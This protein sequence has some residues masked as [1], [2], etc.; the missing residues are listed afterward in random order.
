MDEEEYD[1]DLIEDAADID[2]SGDYD[3]Q[4]GRQRHDVR[5][6]IEELLERKRLREEFGDLDDF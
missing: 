5:R 1:E 3:S 4:I 2:D 6:K